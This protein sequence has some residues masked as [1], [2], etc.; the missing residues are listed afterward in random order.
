MVPRLLSLGLLLKLHDSIS[1]VISVIDEE[2]N[3]IYLNQASYKIW[4][5]HPE[6]LISHKC[7]NLI[8]EE[9]H[10]G[11][12]DVVA[13]AKDGSD[14]HTFE[15]RYCRKDGSIAYMYWEGG[16]DPAD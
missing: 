11:S 14:I 1:E 12:I 8:V 2:G 5:Y 3:F 4:G 13:A 15:N 16:W 9:D 6:E 7:F 10:K